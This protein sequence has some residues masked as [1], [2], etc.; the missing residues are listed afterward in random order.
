M[1]QA[2]VAA[3]AGTGI[4]L[5]RETVDRS[6]LLGILRGGLIGPAAGFILACIV[7]ALAR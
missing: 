3:M 1:N 2:L 5:G 6:Q 4:T 7:E